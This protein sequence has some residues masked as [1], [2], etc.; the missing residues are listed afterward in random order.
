MALGRSQHPWLR[1]LW[2]TL[3]T[4]SS[5]WLASNR[6]GF[7]TAMALT[8][9]CAELSFQLTSESAGTTAMS[10]PVPPAPVLPVL[11]AVLPARQEGGG[12]SPSTSS[13]L[14]S[15]F[16]RSFFLG[17]FWGLLGSACCCSISR[18]PFAP[19]HHK[20]LPVAVTLDSGCGRPCCSR[21]EARASKVDPKT[22]G[23]RMS[24]L[25]RL[26]VVCWL[27]TRALP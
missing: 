20:G 1:V 6:R 27:F 10:A 23:L 7:L 3:L 15:L 16:A 17:F 19:L 25:G 21:I 18:P 9:A 11:L 8:N 22:G 24:S 14:A 26:H 13:P 12:H 5:R 2:L 4:S